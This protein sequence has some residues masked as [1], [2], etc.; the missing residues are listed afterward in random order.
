MEV[1]SHGIHQSRTE[2]LCFDGGVFTNLSHDHLDYHKTFAAY[3]D[4][5][6]QF[7]DTLSKDAFALANVDDRNGNILLQNT[8]AQKRT[9]ALKS[10]ADYTAKVVEKN[11]SGMLLQ[12]ASQEVWVRLIGGFNGTT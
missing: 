5:K 8:K 9:Y 10:M 11:F 4:V 3:R 2:G 6:K 7:F 12:L 1:S